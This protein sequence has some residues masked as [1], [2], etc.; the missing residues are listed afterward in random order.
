MVVVMAGMERSPAH[1]APGARLVLLVFS[2]CTATCM[3][4]SEPFSESRFSPHHDHLRL[5]FSL[6]L[7][8]CAFHY[9]R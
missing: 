3:L 7:Y 4:R 6:H 8:T 9:S 1:A 5:H 2:C